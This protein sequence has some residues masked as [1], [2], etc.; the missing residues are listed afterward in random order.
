MPDKN[1]RPNLTFKQYV[2][3]LTAN[4]TCHHPDIRC[5]QDGHCDGCEYFKYCLVED[6]KEY[7]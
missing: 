4:Q 5:H 7:Q 6:K 2:E 1:S 3:W